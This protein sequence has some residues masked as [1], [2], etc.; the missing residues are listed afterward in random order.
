MTYIISDRL[1]HV[2][3]RTDVL[4]KF[5]KY[6]KRYDECLKILHGFTRQIIEKRRNMLIDEDIDIKDLDDDSI[7]TKK[8]LAFLDILLKSTVDGQPLS[9]ADIAEEVDTFM[10]EG[11][12][13][14]TAAITFT[15]YLLSQHLE[16]QQKVYEE[17]TRIVGSDLKV[18]PTYNQLLEMKYLEC[19]IK[20]S[21][22]LF[23]PVPMIGRSL[24]EDLDYD[25]KIFPATVNLTLSIM[26]L[27]RNPNNFENPDEF[28]P[29]R[30]LDKVLMNDN[31]F[32]FV[33]FSAGNRNCIGQKFAMLELK[34]VISKVVKNFE[35][36]KSD[37]DLKLI[38]QITLKSINGV[39][40]GFKA[41]SF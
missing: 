27:H 2:W 12:D 14:T 41:R 11:H 19:V 9:N 3:Q 10:F 1:M 17:V 36:I 8:K 40:V 15:L 28:R 38:F 37:I 24:D 39:H 34:S 13:T 26:H 25:G 5:S 29:E 33:P 32:M 30:F 35:L 20:E 18:D 6:K 31:A 22:R 23:P 7:G 4:F 21:L 16:V